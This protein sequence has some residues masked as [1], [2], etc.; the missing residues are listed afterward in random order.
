MNK[1]EFETMRTPKFR[2][3]LVSMV[4]LVFAAQAHAEVEL[5]SGQYHHTV[6]DLSVKVM[7][8]K[9]VAQRTWYRKQW[10][11]NRAWNG[12]SI[13][14][15]DLDGS[16]KSVERNGDAYVRNAD[17]SRFVFDLRK[18]ILKTDTGFRWE[19]RDGNWI[20]YDAQGHIARYGD[21]NGLT[22]SFL[23]DDQGRRTGV[24]DRF[25]KQVLWYEYD[26]A[27]HVSAVRDYSS[28]AR[29]VVYHYSGELLTEVVD[30]LGNSW[31]Y[32]YDSAGRLINRVDPDGRPVNVT[33]DQSGRAASVTKADGTGSFYEYDYDST[34]KEYFARTRLS[35]GKVTER[36]YDREGF[37][38]RRDVNG[39]TVERIEKDG[40]RRIYTN[41]LGQQTVREYDEWDNLIKVTWPDGATH[42]YEVDPKFSRVTKETDERGTVTSFAYDAN[43]NLTRKVEAVGTPVERTTEYSHDAYGNLLQQT[44]VG[45]AVTQAATT[46]W[47]Y[48]DFGNLKTV[49]D[50]EGHVTRYDTYDVMGN[51]LGWR[52]GRGNAWQQE[53]DAKGQLVSRTDPLGRA[54]HY[55]Y[56]G[57]GH[58]TAVVDPLGN[59]TRSTYDRNGRLVSVTDAL[60]GVVRNV[61]DADGKLTE[62]RDQEDHPRRFGYDAQGRLA[63]LIDGNGNTITY[64]WGGADHN[65]REDAIASIDYP[66]FTQEY[67][68]N[69][70]GRRTLRIDHNGDQPITTASAYDSSANLTESTDPNGNTTRYAYD[71]LG[72]LTVVTNALGDTVEYTYDN[73]NNLL[74]VKNENDVVIRRFAYDLNDNQVKEIWPLGET[75][76]YSYDA[77]G[78]LAQKID[79][80][81][82]V[83]R[84]TY[85][86]ANQLVRIDY[87]ANNVDGATA[88]KTVTFIYNAAGSLAG[89]ADGTTSGAY[90]Y[91][92]L[93]RKTKAT[94]NYGAFSKAISYAYY[95]DNRERSY[96][97]SDGVTYSYT[98]DAADNLA[99][100]DIPNA[101]VITYNSYYWNA[102]KSVTLPGGGS[103][104]YTYDALMRVIRIRALDPAGN[105]LLDFV[106]TYDAAGRIV[107]KTTEHGMYRY[108]HDLLGRLTVAK[109][110]SSADEAFTYDGAGNRLTDPRITGKWTY[111]TNNQLLAYGGITLKYDSNGSRIS[112]TESGATTQ[113]LYDL[114]NRLSEVRSGEGDLVARYYYDPFGRRLWKEAGGVYTYFIYA[115]EGLSG[116]FNAQGATIRTYG[117]RPGGSRSEHVLF[118]RIEGRIYFYHNDNLGTPQVIV[119]NSGDLAWGAKYDPFGRAKAEK[120][121]LVNNLRFPGQYFD[122]ET[123]DHYNH[124]RT[125]DPGTGRYVQ[126]D[127]LGV[128]GGLNPYLYVNDRPLEL[129]DPFGLEPGDV[130]GSCANADCLF[131]G[132]NL[133]FSAAD[134]VWTGDDQRFPVHGNWC[135]PG[136]TGG[137]EGSW[138]DLTPGQRRNAAQPTDNLDAACKV[139]DLCYASCRDTYSCDAAAR[140]ICFR[141]C[142]GPLA[143]RAKDYGGIDGNLIW[144]A[145]DRSGPRR[146]GPNAPNCGCAE[147]P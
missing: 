95:R 65:A 12:L 75:F 137:H 83:A 78:H 32:Q 49:T 77:N 141:G 7:G 22:A 91:D 131:R 107:E 110:P 86:A 87:Y 16:V 94:V 144:H 2:F 80:K 24:Q 50:P 58:R 82:Q 101:G 98:Y 63:K 17:G 66:T 85:D 61:Y 102:P 29:R 62:I 41:E 10:H 120:A 115:D 135:G 134:V 19:D 27:G 34:K 48:D 118:E 111:N 54:T 130:C 35:N 121:A 42:S 103:R 3:A 145:M 55:E 81:G 4:C 93:Q 59:V 15:D 13:E 116:E 147:G 133:C 18:S 30:V 112:K 44:R 84:Y 57:A 43:G 142:D 79:G 53:Y 90:V 5:P 9:I 39:K 31:T 23:Y 146:A 47:T 126:V 67:R 106:Y 33:Y 97:A 138:N 127:P 104:Q 113:S 69:S 139:H 26:A 51:V 74:A 76:Q 1:K 119:D 40:R 20:E 72:R 125:Y 129:S 14:Y 60:G 6:D 140:S 136:W 25:G 21:R 109:K 105:S 28:P 96:T 38:I 114:K 108:T 128:R 52:D 92:A 68:Y 70:R 89:Y 64:H 37:M 143:E 73:R 8:G 11:F 45:D 71:A 56:D 124:F 88:A 123:N 122:A 36:W 132:G 117:L 46:A 99:S 100:V